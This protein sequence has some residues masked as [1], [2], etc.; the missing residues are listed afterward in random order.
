MNFLTAYII[1]LLD[2]VQTA[3]TGADV[4]FWFIAGFGNVER[5]KDSN[6]SP[7]D[8]PTIDAFI[9]L[10]V[11]GFFCYRIWTLNKRALWICLLIAIV[12]MLLATFQP[13]C[14]YYRL[15]HYS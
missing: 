5:L 3:L 6:F 1:F 9:S 12:R 2:T 15:I 14:C 7:I 13:Y 11:Q 4:Y 8:S 10:I